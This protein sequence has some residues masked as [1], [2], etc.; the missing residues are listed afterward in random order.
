MLIEEKAQGGDMLARIAREKPSFL[1]GYERVCDG[2]G[3]A[4]Y[5]RVPY[6]NLKFSVNE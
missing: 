3:L 2:A 5:R 6:Q 4:L 1:A